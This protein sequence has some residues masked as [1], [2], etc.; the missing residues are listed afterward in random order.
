MIDARTKLGKMIDKNRIVFECI[1]CNYRF[2]GDTDTKIDKCPRCK[3]SDTIVLVD[4]LS[5]ITK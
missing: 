3:W 5:V 2:I 4:N 1:K